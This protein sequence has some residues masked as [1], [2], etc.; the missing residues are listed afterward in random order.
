MSSQVSAPAPVCLPGEFPDAFALSLIY[1]LQ[2]DLCFSLTHDGVN[3]HDE[4]N[5]IWGSFSSLSEM[6]LWCAKLKWDNYKLKY[7]PCGGENGPRN[8]LLNIG[9]EE[10]CFQI[11]VGDL[12][13]AP[14]FD[15]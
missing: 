15:F 6:A 8:Q 1:L 2:R 10:K 12:F 4:E 5:A 13:T 3:E 11:L 7:T 9:S 14:K